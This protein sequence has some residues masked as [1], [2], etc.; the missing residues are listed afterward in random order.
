[1]RRQPR[2]ETPVSAGH[3]RKASDTKRGIT[4]INPLRPLTGTLPKLPPEITAHCGSDGEEE[5]ENWTPGTDKTS[6]SFSKGSFEKMLRAQT[7]QLTAEDNHGLH[8]VMQFD[9]P[10]PTPVEQACDVDVH[11]K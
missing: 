5:K 9:M 8:A 3:H 7:V 10:D 4:L 2:V 1:M 11:E 6:A